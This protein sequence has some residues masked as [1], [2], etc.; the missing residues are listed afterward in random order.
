MLAASGRVKGREAQISA[1][2]SN[3]RPRRRFPCG[4]ITPRGFFNFT[5]GAPSPNSLH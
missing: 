1:P 4:W 5:P 2:S 3:L